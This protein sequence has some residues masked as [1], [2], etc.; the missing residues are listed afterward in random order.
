[1][2]RMK[3]K[4]ADF[5]RANILPHLVEDIRCS[6]EQMAAENQ[7]YKQKESFTIYIKK[8][9]SKFCREFTFELN[10]EDFEEVEDLLPYVWYPREFWDGNLK[11]Y[12]LIERTIHGRSYMSGHFIQKWLHGDTTHFML[13]EPMGNK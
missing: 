4:A 1:M 7:A 13:I 3:Q 9:E 2:L 10:Y 5:L 6:F 12:L 8:G 11:S